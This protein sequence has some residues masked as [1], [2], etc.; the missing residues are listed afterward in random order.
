MEDAWILI[1]ASA[2]NLIQFVVL[3]ELNEENQALC[4]HVI[5]KERCILIACAGNCYFLL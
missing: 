1:I 2:F 4:R 3:V 5:R